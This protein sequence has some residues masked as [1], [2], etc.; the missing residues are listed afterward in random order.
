MLYLVDG[1]NL[2]PKLP[3]FS[4]Q[5]LD[6][7]VRLVELLQVFARVR[8]Q[9]VEVYFDGAPPGQAGTRAYGSIRAHFVPAGQTADEALR[10]RLARMQRGARQVTLVS[11]DRRVQA[12][13]RRLQAAL[14]TSEQFAALLL[15]AK[16]LAD[17]APGAP[18]AVS[19]GDLDEWLRLFGE[20]PQK[21]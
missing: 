20:H 9:T 6:D 10:R 12:E 3:G 8:R 5:E 2:I 17:S 1:H 11:S 18:P 21:G 15:E 14:L 4:L 16:N 13:A 7:E 19:A